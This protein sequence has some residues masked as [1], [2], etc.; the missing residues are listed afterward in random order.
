MGRVV[1]CWN[2]LEIAFKM[3]MRDYL[4]LKD[5]AGWLIIEN[6]GNHTRSNIMAAA[7]KELEKD[8]PTQK[9]IF[10]AIALFNIC[11]ENRNQ[12]MH[13]FCEI[14]GGSTILLRTRKGIGKQLRYLKIDQESAAA[15]L[16]AIVQ[17]ELYVTDLHNAILK[18]GAAR[19]EFLP[20]EIPL[21]KAITSHLLYETDN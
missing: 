21:P 7:A 19:I 16:E 4:D 2:S 14:G 1:V 5:N 12:L 3:L 10:H 13:C 8:Q 9:C 17:S 6:M 15:T 18:Q 11:R 20:I